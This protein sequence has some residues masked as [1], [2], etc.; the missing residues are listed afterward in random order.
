VSG[1]EDT[2]AW[3]LEVAGFPKP[4]RQ[5]RFH[6]TRRWE[7]DFAFPGAVPPLAVE[8]EGGL[9]QASS[10]HRSLKGVLR[11][12]EK[13]NQLCILGWR[14]IRLTSTMIEDGSALTLIEEALRVNT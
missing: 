13:Y 12:I 4:E 6:T 3:Q 1:L 14:L 11:D 10:G 7:L 5:Y 2:L 9:Y 8:I